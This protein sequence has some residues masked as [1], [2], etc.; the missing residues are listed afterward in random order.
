MTTA[1]IVME[2]PLLFLVI[3]ILT[4]YIFFGIH[5]KSILYTDKTFFKTTNF[6]PG[7]L[8]QLVRMSSQYVKVVVLI[9]S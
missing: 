4:I 2:I 1:D 9:P 3:N 6:G 8:S 5:E 7:W